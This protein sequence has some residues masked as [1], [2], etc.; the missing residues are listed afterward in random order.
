MRILMLSAHFNLPTDKVP[1]GGVQRHIEGLTEALKGMG[2]IVDWQYPSLI[3]TEDIEK[4]YDAV[5]SHDYVCY[6]YNLKTPQIIVFHGWEGSWPLMENVVKRRR[7][8]AEKADAVVDIGS[9]IHKMY[10]SKQGHII[11]GG[12]DKELL[13]KKTHNNLKMLISSRIKKDCPNYMAVE[14]ANLLNVELE[15]CGDGDGAL[16]E[17]LEKNAKKGITFHGFVKNIEDYMAD[18][19]F[20]VFGGYLTMI[21]AMVLRKPC[22]AFYDTVG[23]KYRITM[24]PEGVKVFAGDSAQKVYADFINADISEVIE[25]NYEWAVQQ[26][27]ENIA[28]KYLEI[29]HGIKK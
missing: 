8:I 13:K 26:T 5:I 16:R 24:L 27:W 20:L 14:L 3:S 22:F 18:C 15:V 19:S 23:R 9:S 28:V 29:L 17:E 11:Y 10:G 25:K 1:I 4:K 7:E 2:Y 12:Y 21:E 6:R